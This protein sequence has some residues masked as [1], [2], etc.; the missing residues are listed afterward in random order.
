MSYAQAFGADVDS[1]AGAD[2]FDSA[3]MY[4]ADFLRCF[5]ESGLDV[6]LLDEAT[7]TEP[8][9][10]E[11]IEW[12]R[13][14]L[15]VATHYR[16]T[17]GLRLPLANCDPGTVEGVGFVIAPRALAAPTGILTPTSFWAGGAPPPCLPGQF[18]NAEIPADANPELVLDRLASLRNSGDQVR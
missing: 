16:W 8:A 9:L 12:Y 14:V 4:V 3:S 18:L 2:E 7:D 1:E 5:S 17:L 13:P 10:P 15:N 11:E 6:L